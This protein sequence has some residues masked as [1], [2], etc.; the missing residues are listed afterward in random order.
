MPRNPSVL[1]VDQD[2]D[3]R[4]EVV[5]ML[6]V[7][8]FAVVGDAGLGVEA[9]SLARET[10]PE[11]IVVAV[12]EPIARALQTME[13]L[14]QTVP[15]VPLVSYAGRPDPY[16]MRAAM[17]A[18]ARDFVFEPLSADVLAKS[19]R[20][21]LEHAGERQRR[22]AGDAP[23]VEH[24]TEGTVVTVFGAKGGIGKT[25]IATNLSTAL[26]KRAGQSVALVDLDTRFGDV[27]IM[28]DVQVGQSIVDAARDIDR[29]TRDTARDYLSVHQSGVHILPA[30]LD[31]S[32]W[33]S[34]TPD[35]IRAIARVLSQ[36]YDFVV[37]DTPGTFNDIV[38][39]ALEAATL[40]LLTT[41]MDMASIKDTVL[42]L[43]MLRSWSYPGEKVK[44][45]INRANLANSVREEDVE[46]T[47]ST[48]VFWR[49]PYDPTVMA[50]TQIGQ[51]IVM[52]KPRSKAAVS[53]SDLATRLAGI[54]QQ[55]ARQGFF[56]RLLRR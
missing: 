39:A 51:P 3:R 27:A 1:V 48:K 53:I 47:L 21:A 52:A 11:A 46:R 15:E 35:H 29:F 56:G 10:A 55:P 32:G 41:S 40:V 24:L 30:P 54:R 31:P 50:A 26:V 43:N 42:A 9:V 20:A 19:V 5:Q 13:T 45:T 25:T 44:L 49:V 6:A 8:R 36:T 28:M 12:E 23:S 7:S 16:A 33:N 4:A 18:G 14:G 38:G 2:A 34:V 22:Q 37:L 17:K